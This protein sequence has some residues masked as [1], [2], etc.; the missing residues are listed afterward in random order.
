VL[1]A[2]PCLRRIASAYD[3]AVLVKDA[4]MSLYDLARLEAAIKAVSLEVEL[5]KQATGSSASSSTTAGAA[6]ASV[7]R[8]NEEE[9][10]RPTFAALA[11]AAGRGERLPVDAWPGPWPLPLTVPATTPACAP[12]SAPAGVAAAASALASLPPPAFASSTAHSPT[13]RVTL[14]ALNMDDVGLSGRRGVKGR[15]AR[16]RQ[17]PERSS[18][19][20]LLGDIATPDLPQPCN[21]SEDET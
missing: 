6:A 4:S 21:S 16:A 7:A 19:D 11:A 8:N 2:G 14:A 13:A 12:A 3:H 10:A 18:L 17:A 5:L 20:L 9:V 15:S 1:G